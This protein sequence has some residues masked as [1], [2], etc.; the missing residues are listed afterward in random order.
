MGADRLGDR[1]AE[2]ERV[3]S[4][5]V[6]DARRPLARACHEMALRFHRGGRLLCHGEGGA[7][8]DAA[9]VA[10][11]FMHPV[12]V[13][14]VALPALA[15]GN[16]PTAATNLRRLARPDDIL[17]ALAHT[18]AAS[19]AAAAEVARARDLGLLTILFGCGEPR[20]DADFA[21]DVPSDDEDVVQEVQETAYHLLWE[22][23]HVFLEQP[24]L[25]EEACVT[26]GD[27]A[28]RAR[29]VELDRGSALV[30]AEGRRER[31]AI[32]LVERVEVGDLLLCHAGVALE[33]LPGA[34][35]GSA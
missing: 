16:D 35:S 8:T 15:L 19:R 3:L 4:A 7:A 28:V 14:K 34:G 11:E 27:T 2:R 6:A 25:L 17:I 32:D 18:P 10:V 30:E 24:G 9:H 1:I 12:I 29:I 33:R 20:S 22:L 26:C 13:G 21:F 31:V 23:A 5:F